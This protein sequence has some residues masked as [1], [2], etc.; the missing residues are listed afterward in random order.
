MFDFREN[1]LVVRGFL[2]V[3]HKDEDKDEVE[4]NEMETK[5]VLGWRKEQFLSWDSKSLTIWQHDRI[6]KKLTFPTSK[7]NYISCIIFVHKLN[8]F[9]GT[10]LVVISLPESLRIYYLYCL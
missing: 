10:Y 1:K 4:M 8:V 9:I 3:L 7:P 5:F 6:I 2:H